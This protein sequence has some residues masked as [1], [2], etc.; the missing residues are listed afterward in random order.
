MLLGEIGDSE[1]YRNEKNRNI[2]NP[3][4]KQANSLQSTN[5]KLLNR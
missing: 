4:N 5:L 1:K 3:I 2:R